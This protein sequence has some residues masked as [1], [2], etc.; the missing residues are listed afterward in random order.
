M[1]GIQVAMIS[2][3]SAVAQ[4]WCLIKRHWIP[5]YITRSSLRSASRRRTKPEYSPTLIVIANATS[6]KP[7][8]RRFTNIEE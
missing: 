6:V 1:A 2:E 8:D 4:Q 5:G 3:F 7:S